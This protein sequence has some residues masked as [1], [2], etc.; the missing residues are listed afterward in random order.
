MTHT[1]T[2]S[3]SDQPSPAPAPCW[4]CEQPVC[5]CHQPIP[6]QLTPAGLAYLAAAA[7]PAGDHA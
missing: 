5:V 4:R 7:G 6:Y 1:H 3:D 2:G